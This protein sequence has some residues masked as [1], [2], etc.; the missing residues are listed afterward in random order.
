M[1]EQ[2]GYGLSDVQQ[3]DSIDAP[4]LDYLPRPIDS[5]APRLGLIGAGGIAEYHLR[6]YQKLGLDVVAICDINREQAVARQREFYPDARVVDDYRELLRDD[7][8]E[9]VDVATHPAARV[10]IVRAALM[11]RKHV[12]SQKPFVLDLDVGQELV[13]LADKQQ[14]QLAV[15]QNGRWAPHF[16]YL[17]AA[18]QQGVVGSVASVDF[19]LQ[20]DHTWTVATPFNEIHHLILYDFAIHWFDIATAFMDGAMAES[21][22][23]SVRRTSYQQA[24]PPFLAQVALNY[25]NAQVRMGF[26]AHVQYGQEDR[27]I[28]AGERGTLRAFGPSLNEQQVQLWT[29]AG[30][31]HPDLQGCWFENGFEGTMAEL[32]YAIHH[33]VEPSNSAA[34]NLNSLAVCFAGIASANTGTPVRPGAVRQLPE[35]SARNK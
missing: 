8:I 15:N 30:T 7:S 1:S 27:T 14:V 19:S 13:D 5:P 25:P 22:S 17:L 32:L 35:S 26:N 31:A 11:A 2:T 16:A 28:V 34:K 12:L 18:I 20:W 29:A 6:A 3:S 24:K 9:V 4:A 10:E 21:V 33:R 23:A